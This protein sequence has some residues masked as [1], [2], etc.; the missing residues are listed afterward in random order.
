VKRRVNGAFDERAAD[1][2]NLFDLTDRTDAE[3]RAV[4]AKLAQTAIDRG[5]TADLPDV[6]AM[7]G[8][9]PPREETRTA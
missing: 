4:A 9:L 3:R 6:L 7:L 8:L 1:I 2:I 5:A